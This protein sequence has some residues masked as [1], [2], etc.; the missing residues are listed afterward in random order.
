MITL[1]MIIIVYSY[2]YL[3]DDYN[4]PIL[5]FMVLIELVSI[6]PISTLSL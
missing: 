4:S 3:A 1:L 2:D 6:L 5:R